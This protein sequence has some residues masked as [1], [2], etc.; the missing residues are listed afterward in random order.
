MT[1]LAFRLKPPRKKPQRGG[2]RPGAGRPRLRPL[3]IGWRPGRRFVARRVRATV[4]GRSPVHVTMRF[5]HVVRSLRNGK[6]H[7]VIH[8]AIARCHRGDFRVVHYSV[9]GDHIHLIAEA[10]SAEALSSGMQGLTIRIAKALNRRLERSGAVMADRYHA[11]VLRSPTQ[12]RN[13]ILY[14]LNNARKHAAA[15]RG[16]FERGWID[17]FSSAADFD[18]WARP[19]E[20]D[21][22]AL[23]RCT[24]A[25]GSWLLRVGWRRRGLLDPGAVPSVPAASVLDA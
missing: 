11:V 14:V 18:G 23:P 15:T 24:A 20:P 2:K 6:L 9:Q 1:Q 4:G 17:P 19:V 16:W 13:A 3:P 21:R 5:Q 10:R 12:V 7:Q 25:A 8:G 22:L